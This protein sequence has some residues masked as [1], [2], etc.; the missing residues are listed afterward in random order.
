MKRIY[1]LS[2]ILLLSF[3][4]AKSQLAKGEKMIGGIFSYNKQKNDNTSYFAGSTTVS[5]A[6]ITP[7]FGFGI[8]KNWIVGAGLGYLYQSQ[9]QDAGG[10][11]YKA[12]IN[13][14]SGGVLLR[15]FLPLHEKGGVFGQ[16]DG[17]GGF[18]NGEQTSSSFSG[19][20]KVKR[21]NV[22]ATIRPGFYFK[23][24]KRIIIETNFGG[25]T[26]TKTVNKPDNGFKTTSSEFDIT[27][28]SSLGL[29]FQYIF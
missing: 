11:P 21:T 24:F 23:A 9:K 19:T 14:F 26:Y 16:L 2:V 27:L 10:S 12:K 20:S 7:Q 6:T 4:S 13:I 17:G 22:T 3:Y 1:L 5:T 25:L 18:G 29:G 28:A 8:G 15:K